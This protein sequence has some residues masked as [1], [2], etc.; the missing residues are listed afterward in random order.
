MAHLH[1]CPNCDAQGMSVFYE[2]DQVPVHSVLLMETPEQAVHFRRG[3]I[4]LGVCKTCGFVSNIAFDPTVHDYALGYEATQSFSPTF[5]AFHTQ[6]AQQLIDR[7]DL[8]HKHIIEIGC[9]QGEFLIM[10]CDLGDN[11][12]VGF[13][14]AYDFD[15]PRAFDAEQVQ[16]I[17]DFYSEKYTDVKGD[18]ICCKMTLEHISDT[19]E[20]VRTV[21]RSI[22]DRL[23]TIVFFQVPNA[24]YVLHDVAFWDIYYEH[25]S[26]FT[27]GSLA[28][29]F[30]A[31]GFEVLDVALQYGNQY[32]TIEARPVP[33]SMAAV[34]ERSRQAVAVALQDVATFSRQAPAVLHN[35]ETT[36]ASLRQ[37]N[38]QV[39]I[40]GS[41]S[42][43]VAFLTTLKGTDVI[44]YAVDVN[45]YRHD[46]FM[47][48]TGQVIV[49]P[50]FLRLH[51]P[52]VVIVMNPIYCDEIRR[53]L[54]SLNLSPQLLTV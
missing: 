48:G 6:L 20:F 32:L 19:A 15:R 44:Q 3:D 51:P 2:V 27:A 26:Y 10:L 34:S 14:P 41:G 24:S 54:H 50:E 4:R 31:C 25:C 49:G 9:G 45:P 47:A 52:D 1:N 38:Q 23:E 39:A 35:W 18:F 37:Q 43:G 29:L 42:K 46:T 13:D 8:H 30:E 5:N 11:H 17:Q 40:W 53:T 7:Y 21:R 22:G 16:F 33:A 28:Y 12:G 36:L